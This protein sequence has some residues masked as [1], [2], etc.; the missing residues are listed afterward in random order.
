MILIDGDRG[1]LEAQVSAE[2]LD[3]CEP[4]P[5]DLSAYQSGLGRDLFEV[6]RANALGA[7]QGAMTYVIPG[8]VATAVPPTQRRLHDH[9]VFAP[10]SAEVPV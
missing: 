8:Q 4:S 10:N 2:E 7:E 1:I 5:V 9:F 3:S 6:F